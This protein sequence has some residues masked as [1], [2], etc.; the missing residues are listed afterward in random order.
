MTDGKEQRLLQVEKEVD[1]ILVKYHATLIADIDEDGL[2]YAGYACTE[3]L[4]GP[5]EVQ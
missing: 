1:E 2:P 5:S 4:E 3:D